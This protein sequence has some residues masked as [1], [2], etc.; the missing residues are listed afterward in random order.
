ME[1]REKIYDILKKNGMFSAPIPVNKLAKILKIDIVT[2]DFG[3][4]IS[5]VVYFDETHKKV[6]VNP[7]ES[8]STR[9][10][11]ISLAIARSFLL[12]RVDLKIYRRNVISLPKPKKQEREVMLLASEILMPNQLV[13]EAIQEGLKKNKSISD[14]EMVANLAK[15]FAVGQL[16]M[17]FRLIEIGAL[18]SF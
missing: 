4:E 9:R 8:A 12:D 14:D 11:L 7:L 3:A 15:M 2:H 17:T 10:R 16:Q 18:V 5:G 1:V 13:N 6:G